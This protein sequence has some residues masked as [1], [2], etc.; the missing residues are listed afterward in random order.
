M[1]PGAE[2]GLLASYGA[3]FRR[4]LGN[5]PREYDAAMAKIIAFLRAVRRH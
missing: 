4:Q 2:H 1:I 3:H 5:T